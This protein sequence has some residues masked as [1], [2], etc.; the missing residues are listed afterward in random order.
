MPSLDFYSSADYEKNVLIGE[1]TNLS[2]GD[3]ILTLTVDPNSPDDRKMISLDSFDILKPSTVS[4]DTPSLAPIKAGDQTI[5]LTLPS[6][7][8]GMLLPFI[9]LGKKILF[10]SRKPMIPTSP[11]QMEIEC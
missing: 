5:T 10:S 2:N 7:G 6:G 1:Y 8:G 3:H 4:L 9:S 11:Y